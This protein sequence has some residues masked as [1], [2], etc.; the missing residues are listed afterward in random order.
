[1]KR[2]VDRRPQICETPGVQINAAL[3][4]MRSK[5]AL[6]VGDLVLDTYIYGETVR[7]SR[8]APVVVV[9]KERVEHR[10]GG[11]ANAAAN[12]SALGVDTRIAGLLGDD[13]AGERLHSMLVAAGV[14]V[15]A[16]RAAPMST[17]QKTR[18]LA[19]AFGT[20]RQQ[21]LR[22]DD[23]SDR[24]VA[25]RCSTDVA[26]ALPQAIAGV[27]V[28]VL[29][30][31]GT[32][33]VSHEVITAARE[34]AVP[35]CADSRH[36]LASFS[37]VTAVTP[38]VPEAEALVGDAL[39]DN[40]AIERAGAAILERLRCEACLIT[41]GRGGMT[42]FRPGH[43]PRHVDIAGSDEVTDVTGAGDTVAATFA[44]AL[45]A[46]LGMVNGMVLANCAAGVAVMRAGAAT[47]APAEVAAAMAKHG[48]EL[49]P[50]VE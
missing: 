19:G 49:E 8:E 50:W 22:L 12:L 40:S 24:A 43:T 30:D 25:R 33:A 2:R 11:A 27:D 21:V 5:R 28:V 1:M 29:S 9:R 32:G 38:N 46:G 42:L 39:S 35:V 14:G 31:Y 47:V 36:R 6:V 34:A 20:T 4:A 3:Q 37:G 41:Q 10:L 44:A 26:A 17:P 7:V 18:V 15:E 45:A 16:L 23:E 48:L 13:E